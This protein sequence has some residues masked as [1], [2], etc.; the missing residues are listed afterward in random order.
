[1][2]SLPSELAQRMNQQRLNRE[3]DMWLRNEE[4]LISR[5]NTYFLHLLEKEKACVCV[6]SSLENHSVRTR[7]SICFAHS[8]IPSA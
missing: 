7:I 1:M 8:Y 2:N 6:D 3:G 5:D 4:N